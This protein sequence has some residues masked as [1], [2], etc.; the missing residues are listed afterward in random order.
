MPQYQLSTTSRYEHDEKWVV[1]ARS[2][3]EAFDRI[4]ELIKS[5]GGETL[6]MELLYDPSAPAHNEAEIVDAE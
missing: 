6:K 1:D 2:E 3:E 4:A 5:R